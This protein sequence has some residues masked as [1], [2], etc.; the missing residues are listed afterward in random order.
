MSFVFRDHPDDPNAPEREPALPR[1]V[2][3]DAPIPDDLVDRMLDGDIDP[4]K[5]REVFGSIRSNREASHRLDATKRLL[6]TLKEADRGLPC[7]DFSRR[8]LDAVAARNGLFSAFGFRRMLTYRYAAAAG[9][10]LTVSGLF[11]GQ[12]LAPDTMSLQPRPTPLSRVVQ[13]MPTETAGM[14]TGVRSVFSSIADA[15][16]T[17]RPSPIAVR[18]V[19]SPQGGWSE[20]WIGG[21]NPPVARILWIDEGAR[22]ARPVCRRRVPIEEAGTDQWAI[23]KSSLGGVLLE[24]QTLPEGEAGVVFVSSRR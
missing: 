20:E 19:M 22:P 14:F 24:G 7:P 6:R 8:V 18:R 4:L 1:E 16:P 12:R 21:V 15:M 5:A 17:P 9:L 11:I 10:L 3:A 13:S 2:E 23:M